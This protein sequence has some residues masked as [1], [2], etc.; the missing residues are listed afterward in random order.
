MTPA[1]EQ[2]S[3]VNVNQLLDESRFGAIHWWIFAVCVCVITFDG[4]DLVAYGTMASASALRFTGRTRCISFVSCPRPPMPKR[5][6]AKKEPKS[7]PRRS[8]KHSGL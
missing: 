2:K 3:V 8:E 5:A 7:A 6:T 4:Y 1:I